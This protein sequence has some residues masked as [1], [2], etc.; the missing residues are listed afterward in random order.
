[1]P[2]KASVSPA[3]WRGARATDN[4]AQS[5]R[6]PRGYA[7]QRGAFPRGA[8]QRDQPTQR[9][10]DMGPSVPNQKFATYLRARVG[11]SP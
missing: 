11:A 9:N 8:D 5:L 4:A 7:Q 1:M 3:Y 2:G 10:L 6:V